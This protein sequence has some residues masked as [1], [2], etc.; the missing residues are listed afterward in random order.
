MQHFFKNK[1]TS[2]KTILIVSACF[3][4]AAFSSLLYFAF[5][6]GN[7]DDLP[8]GPKT[9]LTDDGW[10]YAFVEYLH[11]WI[12]PRTAFLKIM[13]HPKSKVPLIKG[14]Y[15][16]TD[17]FAFVRI[18]GIDAPRAMHHDTVRHRPHRWIE[19][20]RE[21]WNTA[22]RYVWN[23]TQPNRT[24]RLHNLKVIECDDYL[25]KLTGEDKI[26]EADWEFLLGGQWHN[27]GVF[28]MQDEMAR[29]LQADG[30][31]WDSG[32]RH[33]SLENPNVPQ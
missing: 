24:F 7:D 8:L 29:P 28:A 21:N 9:E 27:L 13:A 14:G 1:G 3:C 4:I 23:L 10:V 17:V 31:Q 19:Q 22:M 32:T 2:E 12:D 20:E 16:Q 18:R 6:N 26:L 5:A 15:A 11:D 30:T 33:Y 25:K